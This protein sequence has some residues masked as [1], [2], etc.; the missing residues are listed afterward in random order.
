M[1][2]TYCSDTVYDPREA[3]AVQGVDRLY[4]EATYGD[5]AAPKAVPRGH[6]TARQAAMV[7]R[8]AG[9]KRLILGHYSKRYVDEMELLEQAREIFPDTILAN[10]GMRLDLN[11]TAVPVDE[12]MQRCP[13]GH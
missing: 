5:D 7:A 8:E 3:S 6:S 9:V 10:E 11:Q 13:N 1:S 4:H 2:Y 12:L